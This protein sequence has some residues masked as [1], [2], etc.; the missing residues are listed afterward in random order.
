MRAAHGF[1]KDISFYKTTAKADEIKLTKLKDLNIPF[2]HM[3]G[4]WLD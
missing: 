3:N 1:F 4:D 2:Y